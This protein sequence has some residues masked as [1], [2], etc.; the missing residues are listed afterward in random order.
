[1][2]NIEFPVLNK[3]ATM[4]LFIR[5][6]LFLRSSA[7]VRCS[8]GPIL[9]A[10][11]KLVVLILVLIFMQL[12]IQKAQ[13]NDVNKEISLPE[14]TI[15]A[16]PLEN[17]TEL[18]M[19]QPVTVLEGDRLLYK[20]ESSLGDTLSG[21]LGVASSSFG[22]GAG[23]PIIRGLGGPR[24]EILDN[25]I[26]V[27]DVSA[28]SADH[29][30]TVESINAS[31]I[32][33]LRGPTTLLYGG[34]AIG[35]VIN[36]VSNKIPRKKFEKLTGYF[37]G[38][39]N[40]STKEK[41]GSFDV[42]TSIGNH[43]SLNASGFRK[44]TND[45]GIPGRQNR[46]DPDHG[47]KGTV[48]NSR[49]DAGGGSIGGSIIGSR[50][51]IG[52]SLSRSERKYGI[53]SEESPKIDFVKNRYDIAG[54]LNRPIVGFEK[55]NVKLGYSDYRHKE[56]ESDG[57]VAAVFSNQGIDSRVE[58]IH[59]QIKGWKGVFGVQV[60]D[61]DFSAIGEETIVPKTNS[62]NTSVF[63]VEERRWNNFHIDIGARYEH[64]SLDPKADYDTRK[65]DLHGVSIGGK[66]E[67]IGGYNIGLSGTRGQRA[68]AAEELYTYGAHHGTETFQIAKSDL[69]KE[70]SNN[71]DLSLSKTS[72]AIRWKTN[73][74]Y[75]YFQ[76]YIYWANADADGNGIADRVDEEGS[77]DPDG[78]LLVQNVAQ[79]GAHF[80][81]VEAEIKFIFKPKVLDLRL[82]TDY[83]RARLNGGG[84]VPRT[85]PQ[86][87]G[88]EW[89][90]RYG[91]WK[92]N[93]M[94][95]HVLKQNKRAALETSTDEYTMVNL[96]AGY[97]MKMS[98]STKLTVFL[99]GKN[100]MNE[101][102]RIHTSYLKDF[103]P[104]PGRAL[105]IGVRGQ[106]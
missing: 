41:S 92:L 89:N 56:M 49:I 13:A 55:M 29:A 8:V 65:F 69:K 9:E 98:R 78:E 2:K 47:K 19:A 42:S 61:R 74:F 60:K 31:K 91:P 36:V 87:F 16:N 106:F 80:W 59:N 93:L 15:M 82:F 39:G 97:T 45:Y 46:N 86:R 58:F 57:E 26:D 40:T 71:I 23:R 99:Q 3:N 51:F 43:I 104:R 73:F 34:G 5:P 25:G 33:I 48:K 6:I 52:G 18:N 72:G 4:L 20:Q 103:A 37:E 38:R 27:L 7:Y 100:L 105:L 32:E 28:L 75:N 44:K 94:A 14:V 21:E 12:S 35:G 22:P 83:M 76:N 95:I 84:N 67:P 54:E 70:T 1:M 24:I 10:L 11:K 102:I 62:R 17:H 90:H 85:T 88:L 77:L 81:G 30:V 96:A 101:D 64:A 53:P 63:L 68:P 50:G 79:R 66:W